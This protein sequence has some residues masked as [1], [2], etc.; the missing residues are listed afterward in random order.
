[1]KLKKFEQFIKEN[2]N[3]IESTTSVMTFDE[4]LISLIILITKSRSIRRRIISTT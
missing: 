3:G 2:N 1:M 4:I